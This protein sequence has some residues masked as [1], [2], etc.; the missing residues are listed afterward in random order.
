MEKYRM[1]LLRD[2]RLE[3]F[4]ILWS[5][6]KDAQTGDCFVRAIGENKKIREGKMSVETYSEPM[7]L[8]EIR[9]HVENHMQ[10]LGS[11]IGRCMGISL[12]DEKDKKIYFEEAISMN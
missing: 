1:S 5:R 10:M 8:D 11:D 4:A 12:D 6:E 7:T 3:Y 2:G 9:K